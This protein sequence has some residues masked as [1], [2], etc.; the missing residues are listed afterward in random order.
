[1]A[2]ILKE[3]TSLYPLSL[4]I[5]STLIELDFLK[6]IVRIA[7]PIAASAAA[8]TRINNEN[9][10]PDK[11]LRWLEN[12][13]KFIFAESNISSIDIKMVIRFFLLINIPKKP[14]EKIKDDKARK[15]KDS[16]LFSFMWFTQFNLIISFFLIFF[17][18]IE[19]FNFIFERSVWARTIAPII[20]NNKRKPEIWKI[21]K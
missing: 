9:I 5:V 2:K 3:K 14:I 20:A 4:L 13:I 15:F 16:I 12:P 8:T 7:K 1:M 17:W 18:F 10:W 19:E 11:S 21:M 6:N